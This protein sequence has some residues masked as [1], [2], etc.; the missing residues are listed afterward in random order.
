MYRDIVKKRGVA[1]ST[2]DGLDNINMLGLDRDDPLL[3]E[4]LDVIQAERDDF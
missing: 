3:A 4:V 1:T 2:Q